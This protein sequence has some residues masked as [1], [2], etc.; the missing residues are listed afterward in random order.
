M[1]CAHT[2][3]SLGLCIRQ[4]TVHKGDRSLHRRNDTP[5]RDLLGRKRKHI[6]TLRPAHALH[7]ACASERRHQ[8]LKI[9]L[10]DL[11]RL[12]NCLE[13]DNPL[14]IVQGEFI[15]RRHTVAPLC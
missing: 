7:K 3:L 8:L 14:P 15:K 12:C 9:V 6:P 1:P 2:A 10:R 5:D 11:L 13:R 4:Q